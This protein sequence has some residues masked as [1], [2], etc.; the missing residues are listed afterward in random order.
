ME[1]LFPAGHAGDGFGY[2]RYEVSVLRTLDTRF[3]YHTSKS[4]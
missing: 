1:I 4:L 2:T 3:I